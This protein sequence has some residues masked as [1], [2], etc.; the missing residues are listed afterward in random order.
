MQKVERFDLKRI[1]RSV[2]PLG[3]RKRETYLDSLSLL[4][5]ERTGNSAD[6]LFRGTRARSSQY[7]IRLLRGERQ[8]EFPTMTVMGY[9]FPTRSRSRPFAI[10]SFGEPS[11]RCARR[12]QYIFDAASTSSPRR[13][14]KPSPNSESANLPR[15][16]GE[17]RD[18]F[19]YHAELLERAM[20]CQWDRLV[21]RE[22]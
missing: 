19:L 8:R 13:F 2:E 20:P 16:P 3:H 6:P 5:G 18:P 11:G 15:I 9:G 21:P 14:S 7:L 22:R 10:M 17:S 1:L 4:A 12:C